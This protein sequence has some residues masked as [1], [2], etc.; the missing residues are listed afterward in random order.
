MRRC[1]TRQDEDSRG[2]IVLCPPSALQDRL[3]AALPDPVTA[4]A[5]GW[6]RVRARARQ[7]GVNC[8]SWCPITPT[9]TVC[10]PPSRRVGASEIWVTHGQEDALVHWCTLRGLEARPLGMVGYGD[11]DE[12]DAAPAGAEA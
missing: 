6:M 4:F 3:D 10:A 12:N 2:E 5:S 1:A 7:R 9:G 8:G 11:E